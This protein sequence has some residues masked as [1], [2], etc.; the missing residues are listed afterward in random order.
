MPNKF[1]LLQNH[2]YAEKG[3]I[4]EEYLE[5]PERGLVKFYTTSGH[6][7]G[8]I[9]CIPLSVMDTWLE[10][11]KE[12]VTFTKTQAEFLKDQCATTRTWEGDQGLFNR[13]VNEHTSK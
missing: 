10:E 2:P 4:V 8:G 6:F 13:F 5:V 12:E 7:V 1:K 11:V 3:T 9:G